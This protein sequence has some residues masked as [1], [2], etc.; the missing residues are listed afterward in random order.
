MSGCV[1]RNAAWVRPLNIPKVI[2]LGDKNSVFKSLW[3]TLPQTM[4]PSHGIPPLSN[5]HVRT[6]K[7]R[8]HLVLVQITESG[9]A[10][11]VVQLHNQAC[12]TKILILSHISFVALI[13][14][15]KTSK[16]RN[17]IIQREITRV[18][19]IWIAIS[20]CP[21]LQENSKI[22]RYISSPIKWWVGTEVDTKQCKHYWNKSEHQWGCSLYRWVS[23]VTLQSHLYTNHSPIEVFIYGKL[24]WVA[25]CWIRA[26]SDMFEEC[27][28]SNAA[29]KPSP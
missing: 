8:L 16:H 15:S 20:P 24:L 13:G 1:S 4:R 28:E 9:V 22:D 29:L 2:L 10:V 11:L 25:Q 7:Q 12:S 26:A 17:I 21:N 6:I 14:L 23:I 5:L 27:N 18:V 3:S 19:V